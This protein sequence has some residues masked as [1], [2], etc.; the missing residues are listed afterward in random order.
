MT[1]KLEERLAEGADYDLVVA[2]GPVGMMRGVTE[3]R[4]P[5]GVWRPPESPTPGT[6]EN[7]PV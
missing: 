4:S 1:A 7:R 5:P 3:F 6:W 2:I